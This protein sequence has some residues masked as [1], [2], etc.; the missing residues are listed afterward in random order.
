MSAVSILILA[1]LLLFIGL[2]FGFVAGLDW[3]DYQARTE[4]RKA[5]YASRDLVAR[6]RTMV[7]GVGERRMYV[8][9]NGKP[10]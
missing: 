6:P 5:E 7:N 3:R 9:R 2:I 10:L 4:R 8:V 1:A